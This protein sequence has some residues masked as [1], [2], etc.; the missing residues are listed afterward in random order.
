MHST[1]AGLSIFSAFILES[2]MI[3]PM[4]SLKI[5]IRPNRTQSLFSLYNLSNIIVIANIFNKVIKTINIM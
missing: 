2:L 3:P 4:R 1:S 5:S